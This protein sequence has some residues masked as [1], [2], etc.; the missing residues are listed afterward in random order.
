MKGILTGIGLSLAVG[1]AFTP[2]SAA[3]VPEMAFS[4]TGVCS[5]C[6]GTAHAELVLKDYTLGETMGDVNLVSFT[7]DG[8]NLLS[9]FAITP[10][11]PGLYLFGVIDGPFPAAENVIVFSTFGFFTS[12]SGGGWCAGLVCGGDQGSE[13]QWS[14][15]AGVPEPTTWAMMVLGFGGIGFAGYRASRKALG[16]NRPLRALR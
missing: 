2:A 13:S 9:G 4:F 10:T 15:A 1:C 7:Y 3:V 11:S 16:S 12:S 6:D 8:T 5:D 14:T